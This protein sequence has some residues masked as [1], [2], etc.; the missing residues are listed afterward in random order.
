MLLKIPKLTSRYIPVGGINFNTENI[1]WWTDKSHF[2]YPNILINLTTVTKEQLVKSKINNNIFLLT[3]SGGFQVISGQCSINWKQSIDIQ[4]QLG[5]SK[6]FAFDKPP[7]KRKIEGINDFI[8]MNDKDTKMQIKENLDV[9][10]RQSNYLK[11][12]YPEYRERFCYILHGAN[13][14]HWDYNLQLIQEKLGGS[15]EYDEYF[16]G[17]IVYAI[18]SNDILTLGIAAVHAKKYFISRKKYVHFLGCG[19]F[20]KMIILIRNKITTFDSSN[21]LIGNKHWR[22]YNPIDN[23]F[24]FE[25][26]NINYTKNYCICPVC[27]NND[28]IDLQLNNPKKYGLYLSV[29]N[30]WSMLKTNVYLDSLDLVQYTKVVTENFSLSNNVIK[31]LEFCDYADKVGLEL[32]YKKYKPYLKSDETKQKGLF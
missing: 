12:T 16:P 4:V 6:I 9:A 11:A 31:C 32:A 13:K 10:I 1:D 26:K 14:E 17:G 19:S 8:Y 3:D 23:T 25:I 20:N 21:I 2:L 18:K 24:H 15:N 22:I 28:M 30:L 27:S 7:V 29:H 5:A